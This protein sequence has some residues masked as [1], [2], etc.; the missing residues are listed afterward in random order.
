MVRRLVMD[1]RPNLKIHDAKDRH[2]ALC[3]AAFHGHST[4]MAFLIEQEV[5]KG[6]RTK[7]EILETPCRCHLPLIY[8]AVRA[9]TLM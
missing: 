1:F 7:A 5:A 3:M 9:S 2:N 6:T 4:V 8:H